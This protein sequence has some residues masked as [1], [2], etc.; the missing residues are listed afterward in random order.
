[1]LAMTPEKTGYLDVIGP[2]IGIESS[3]YEY[4]LTKGITP[5][6]DFMLGGGQ[7]YTFSDPFK[8]SLSVRI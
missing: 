1:M 7:T 5:S 3:A 4:V 8:S 6:E 2:Q